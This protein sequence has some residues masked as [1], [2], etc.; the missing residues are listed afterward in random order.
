[1]RFFARILLVALF[2]VLSVNASADN[3][4]QSFRIPKGA[5]IRQIANDLEQQ[6]F[7]KTPTLFLFW[8]KIRSGTPKPGNYELVKGE[9]SYYYW[10]QIRQGPRPLRITFPEGWTSWQM[11]QLLEDK[12]I[13]RSKEF[14]EIVRRDTLEGRLFPDTYLFN[15]DL[16]AGTVI[17]RMRERFDEKKPVD[18]ETQAKKLRLSEPQLLVLASIVEREA[19]A[20]QEL[21]LVARVFLNRINKRWLLESCATVQYA[22]GLARN[23]PGI[24]KPRLYYK[25]L[26]ISS[27]FN[28]YRQRGFPPGPIGNPGKAALEA[29]A[30][31]AETDAMFFVAD[32][33]GTHRF[34]RYYKDHLNARS[35]R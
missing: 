2:S 17:Q 30:H 12:G 11:A 9:S 21:P 8:T 4:A 15:S 29:A 23:T 10:D 7:L 24:W 14:L 26:E 34:S 28:T 20:P 18:W 33:E 25:D 19:R 35:K 6:G 1:M 3:S 13:T 5:S 22:I 31:P 32:G 16:P 27:P